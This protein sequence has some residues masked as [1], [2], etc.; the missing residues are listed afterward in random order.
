MRDL[1]STAATTHVLFSFS[2][3]IR[4]LIVFAPGLK[5][6][7]EEVDSLDVSRLLVRFS[8]LVALDAFFNICFHRC[9]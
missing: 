8:A 6:E 9:E 1:H 3:D 5:F 2:T 4:A 7:K